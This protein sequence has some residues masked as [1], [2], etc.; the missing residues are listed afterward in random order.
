MASFIKYA[1]S[2]TVRLFSSKIGFTSEISNDSVFSCEVTVRII[3]RTTEGSSPNGEGA[4]TPGAKAAFSTSVH[5]VRKTKSCWLINCS[6][7]DCQFVHI[8]DMHI[9][10]VFIFDAEP[11]GCVK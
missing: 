2:F 10:F 8:S 3:E 5:K 1:P 7:A 6:R 11:I 4:L 9:L